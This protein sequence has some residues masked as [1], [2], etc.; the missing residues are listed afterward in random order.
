ML[1]LFEELVKDSYFPLAIVVEFSLL[2]LSFAHAVMVHFDMGHCFVTSF[3]GT[4]GH[5]TIRTYW[6]NLNNS[7][8]LC[9][10]LSYFEIG[11]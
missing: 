4:R 10:F 7:L 5:S 9:F 2:H 6:V 1:L 8:F 3:R 11:S